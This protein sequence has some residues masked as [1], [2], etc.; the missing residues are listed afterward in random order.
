MSAPMSGNVGILRHEQSEAAAPAAA[1][2][3]QAEAMGEEWRRWE[4]E[5]INGAFPLLRFLN[6]S[7]HSA[8]F[9][10]EDKAHEH[11]AIKLIPADRTLTAT[12]LSH[13]RTAGA[14]SHPHLMRLFDAGRCELGVRPYLFVVME[15][16]E[17]SLAQILPQR[18]LTPEEVR[19]MLLPTLEA[20]AFLHRKN[21][22]QGGLKPPNVLVVNDRLKLASDTIR[23]A[24]TAGAPTAGFVSSSVYDPPEAKEGRSTPAGDIWSLGITLVEALTQGAAI[25]S[26]PATVPPAFAELVQRC[27]SHD[28]AT[29]PTATELAAELKRPPPESVT[30]AQPVE[31]VVRPAADAA[32]PRQPL[33]L[34]PVA[35][36]ALVIL[37]VVWTGLRLF[38]GPAAGS[39]QAAASTAAVSQNPQTPPPSLPA[40]DAPSPAAP[41]RPA[42]PSPGT[43][44]TTGAAPAVLHE[45]IPD[46]PRSARAT[47]QGRI[48]VAVRVSVDA[49]GNVVGAA[50][51]NPGPSRYFA[52]LASEAARKWRFT[53]ADNTN[54]RQWLLR[55]EFARDGTTAHATSRR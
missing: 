53:P 13:W 52:R 17:E 30:V 6:A 31:P 28:P 32:T 51:D 35:V 41:S 12:Q 50:L 16:A 14:L 5:V 15:Y 27:L 39:R 49:S 37:L 48:R 22:V 43:G 25:A 11:A 46:V 47:I 20:L 19:Q 21:L 36:A 10:T 54:T 45:Q 9:L 34:L 23:P 40:I 8:V 29:R 38:H 33:R 26:L 2:V 7:D 4:G 55:F 3:R 44:R 24:G 42:A 1:V 18:P